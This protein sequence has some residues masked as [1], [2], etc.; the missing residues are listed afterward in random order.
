VR[1]RRWSGRWPADAIDGN[2]QARAHDPSARPAAVSAAAVLRHGALR[3]L[4]PAR[5]I[6]RS[7]VATPTHLIDSATYSELVRAGFRR[8]GV[9]T[10]RPYC[11]ACR[12]CQPVRLKVAEF[13]P[14]RSQ[15]RALNLHA[16]LDRTR[17]QPD[18][19]RGALP[20][21]PALSGGAPFRGRHGP[22]QPRSVRPFPA[23][24]PCR[25]PAGRIPRR[26]DPAHRQHH[27]RARRRALFGLHL[28]RPGHVPARAMAPSQ[29]SGRSRSA[30]TSACPGCIWATG[31]ATAAR[32]PTR[33]G[34]AR[35]RH[36]VTASGKRSRISA[37]RYVSGRWPSPA[38]G[39]HARLAR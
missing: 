2:F 23:A 24:N 7:Q 22:G 3:L 1:A 36:C 15:R 8:S 6:A 4:L 26:R 20:A 10:Y 9:F 16:E 37:R 25:Q 17:V 32:W 39:S 5:R 31:F 28:L 14:N 34:S 30:S 27:R 19:S 18:V 33:P 13:A 11:D 29:S 21:L 38:A 12:E 35:S